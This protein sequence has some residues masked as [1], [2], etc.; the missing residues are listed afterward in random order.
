MRRT[1]PAW[2]TDARL[3][4]PPAAFLSSLRIPMARHHTCKQSSLFPDSDRVLFDGALGR[5]TYTPDFID[6]TRA[7]EWFATLRE[8]VPWRAE[9]RVMYER[10]LD[11]PRLHAS[12]AIADP[13]LLPPLR[14]AAA[15]LV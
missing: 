6:A 15:R 14:E 7:A 9:R 5:V 11:V 8:Q 2:A 4:V 3:P 10:E 13:H 12:A 1:G